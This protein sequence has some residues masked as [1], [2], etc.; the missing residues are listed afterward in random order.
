MWHP[1]RL[2]GAA[3]LAS[4]AL[5]VSMAP[6]AAMA[7]SGAVKLMVGG[8]GLVGG[9]PIVASSSDLAISNSFWS[10]ACSESTLTGTLGQNFKP[11]GNSVIVPEGSFAGG[12][13]EG[14]CASEPMG[15][16]F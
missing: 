16:E 5:A 2:T 9:A 1:I 10:V 15:E 13:N 11:A 7:Q 6:G 14:L 12:G 3:L 4:L 8:V